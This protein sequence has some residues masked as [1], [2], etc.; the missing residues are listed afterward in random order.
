MHQ[1]DHAFWIL[2]EELFELLQVYFSLLIDV[3]EAELHL[4]FFG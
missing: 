2:F 1:R 3:E 4:P